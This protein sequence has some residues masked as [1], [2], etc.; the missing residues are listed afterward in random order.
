[1]AFTEHEP[2]GERADDGRQLDLI[3]EPRECERQG[4]REK[5]LVVVSIQ[6][7]DDAR[8]RARDALAEDHDHTEKENRHTGD[9][10]DVESADLTGGDDARDDGEDDQPE[11]VVDDGRAKDDLRLGDVKRFQI[12]EHTGRDSDARGAKRGRE[13][14]MRGCGQ[15]RKN[16][17]ADEVSQPERRYDSNERDDHGTRTDPDHLRDARLQTDHEQEQNHTKAREHPET[18]PHEDV[19]NTRR[20]GHDRDQSL[21]DPTLD[22]L[23]FGE[24][25]PRC[26]N[27]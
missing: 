9:S 8:G 27:H 13:K 16:P 15:F 20:A 11:H 18:R 10:R 2:R 22:E 5:Q 24:D 19:L 26:V 6:Y 1:M 21:T 4:E 7:A 12:L 23:R 17:R 14:Q 3:R 25:L